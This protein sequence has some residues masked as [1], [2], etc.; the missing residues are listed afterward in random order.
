MSTV[1]GIQGQYK[2]KSYAVLYSDTQTTDK[3]GEKGIAL[4]LHA[5]PEYNYAFG[6]VGPYLY[7]TTAE[8]LNRVISGK[9]DR[10]LDGKTQ[11]NQRFY[12]NDIA[13]LLF[14]RLI[15]NEP[16]ALIDQKDLE[17]LCTRFT[18]IAAGNDDSPY[19]E[20]PETYFFET[21]WKYLSM[22]REEFSSA[23]RR[24]IRRMSRKRDFF[25]LLGSA[26]HDPNFGFPYFI[27]SFNDN[28]K[29]ELYGVTLDYREKPTYS[30]VTHFTIGSGKKYI[31]AS[32]DNMLARHP[33]DGKIEMPLRD[34]MIYTLKMLQ[35]AQREDQYS[36]GFDITVV[37]EDGIVPYRRFID[38]NMQ[39]NP[40]GT[41]ETILNTIL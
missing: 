2:G 1:G 28:G 35:I 6:S 38:A 29:V 4:K 14:S 27:F 12:S 39:S 41:L 25:N 26:L 22:N 24:D 33:R 36:S 37:K 15:G 21:A 40:R 10:I 19:I 18:G 30:P 9:V 34:A 23:L 5:S 17:Y 20:N 11:S 8:Y 32:R 7:G 13:L 16:Q 3:N 31:R